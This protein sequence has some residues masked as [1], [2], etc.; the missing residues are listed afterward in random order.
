MMRGRRD[1]VE[2]DLQA[3]HA[4]DVTGFI[5]AFPSFLSTLGLGARLHRGQLAVFTCNQIAQ[6]C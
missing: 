2:S 5:C 3:D 1:S 6:G 4:S